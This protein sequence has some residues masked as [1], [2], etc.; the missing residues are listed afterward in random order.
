MIYVQVKLYIYYSYNIIETRLLTISVTYPETR[1]S[2]ILCNI[3]HTLIQREIYFH[4]MIRI[5]FLYLSH[6]ISVEHAFICYP[7]C[8]I[9]LCYSLAVLRLI[10]CILRCVGWTEQWTNIEYKIQQCNNPQLSKL[11]FNFLE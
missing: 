11:A 7:E 9:L 1:I 4:N 10:E 6:H 2:P 3:T 8:N 5:F